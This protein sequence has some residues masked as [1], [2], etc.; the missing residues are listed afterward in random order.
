MHF[1]KTLRLAAPLAVTM[2]VAL[3]VASVGWSLDRNERR[4]GHLIFRVDPQGENYQA[5]E[6][7]IFNRRSQPVLPQ[8]VLGL[9]MD[10][11]LNGQREVPLNP[12][13]ISL[14]Q[15]VVTLKV[16]DDFKQGFILRIRLIWSGSTS[17]VQFFIP[18][19]PPA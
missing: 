15:N 10:Y 8:S 2:A 3:L 12:A 17:T 7:S 5:L 19:K 11:V 18:R 16:P 14:N 13:D 9:R 1:I 4:I 6:V